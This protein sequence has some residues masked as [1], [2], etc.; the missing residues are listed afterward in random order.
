MC[1]TTGRKEQKMIKK[2]LVTI[3][4]LVALSIIPALATAKP[5]VTIAI[6]AETE[7]PVKKDGKTVTKRVAAKD[8]ESGAVVFYTV[9]FRN[10]G[11]EKATGVVIENPIP[12][13]TR[14]VP[15]SAHG[16]GEVTFSIDKGKS[17][18]K[19]T[20]LVYEVKDK[21]GKAV[22]KVASPDGYTHIRWVIPVVEAGKK[23]SVGYQAIIK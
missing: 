13:D 3:G 8:V 20:L 11:D 5:L 10:D 6:Q 16:E 15:G 4:A 23:G 17:Y 21:Q 2:Y 12:K 18:N 14:Y 9:N 22:T 1:T 19:P 7:V